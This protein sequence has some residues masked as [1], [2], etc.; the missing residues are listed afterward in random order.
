MCSSDLDYIHASEPERIAV[1]R[2]VHDHADPGDRLFTGHG[3]IARE[4]RI[5]AYDYSGLNSPVITQLR[6][7]NRNTIGVLGPEWVTRPGLMHITSQ[8][9]W[10]YQLARTF[11]ARSLR[12]GPGWRV[13]HK[14]EDA[15]DRLIAV[16]VASVEVT[17]DG[18][19]RDIGGG[20][21][22]VTGGS[23]GGFRSEERRVWK[24]CRSRWSPAH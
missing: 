15:R 21:L 3:Y 6:Q 23:Q 20:L 10:A 5:Y 12:G 9:D 24:E 16:P 14:S 1:G 7:K 13:W 18:P 19:V 4:A 22:H 8:R 11:Y 17:S 2:Y